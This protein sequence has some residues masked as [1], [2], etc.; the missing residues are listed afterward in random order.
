M[1]LRMSRGFN[2]WRALWHMGLLLGLT[3]CAATSFTSQVQNFGAWPAARKASTFVFDV[4]PSQQAAAQMPGAWSQDALQAAALPTLQAQGF[5]PLPP[6]QA[7]RADVLVQLALQVRVEPRMRYEPWGPYRVNGTFSPYP[8]RGLGWYGGT[9]GPGWLPS[10]DPPW[11][12]IRVDVVMRD[13]RSSVV[14][15]E[16]HASHDS[17][18]AVDETAL[19]YLFEAAFQG[20]PSAPPGPRVVDIPLPRQ[21]AR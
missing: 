11:V 15:Y 3:G 5:M 12:T 17:L 16:T 6:E 10:I 20:F 18:G 14:L 13:R 19:P 9:W 2:L 21:G 4:L 8:R 1:P 7:D